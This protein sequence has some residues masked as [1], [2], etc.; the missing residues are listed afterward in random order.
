M[1]ITYV[2][3]KEI[4]NGSSVTKY[5]AGPSTSLAGEKLYITR[6]KF[7]VRKVSCKKTNVSSLFRSFVL[8]IIVLCVICLFWASS[9][10]LKSTPVFWASFLYWSLI[11]STSFTPFKCCITKT[12][13]EQRANL[14][15]GISTIRFHFG[16]TLPVEFTYV[17]Q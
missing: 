5:V 1:E 7:K 9:I 11:P 4:T 10:S 6:K 15:S 3:Q 17:N 12:C 16:N 8:S 14:G 13:L 2:N